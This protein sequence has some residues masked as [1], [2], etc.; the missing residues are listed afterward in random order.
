[1]F[2]AMIMLTWRDDLT[3]E[4]FAQWWLQE[5]APMARELPNVRRIVFNLVEQNPDVPC[6]GITELWLGS[7]DD[8]D[9]AYATEIGKK[10]A[11][12]S[13]AHLTSRVRLFVD[14]QSVA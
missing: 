5:H 14:E 11:A 13:L 6:D 12:D 8:F 3:H 1:M 7:R 4:Q 2:K 10:V 9:A